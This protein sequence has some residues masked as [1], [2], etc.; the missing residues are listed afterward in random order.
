MVPPFSFG[1]LMNSTGNYL[2]EK[3]LKEYIAQLK[4]LSFVVID[5]ETK[6]LIL[7]LCTKLEEK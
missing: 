4:K 7:K 2:S 5:K 6:D 3:D 1:A